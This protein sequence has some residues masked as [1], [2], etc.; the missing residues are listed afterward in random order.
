MEI[1]PADIAGAALNRILLGTV[2]PRPIAW[3]S[4]INEREQP[5]LAPFSFFN[6][7]CTR[8]PTLLFCPGVRGLD[9]AAKDTLDNIRATGEYVI[10]VVTQTTAEAMNKTATELPPEINEFEFA[11]LTQAPSVKVRPPRVG[12]S[13]VNFECE[14]RQIV[15]IGDGQPGSGWIVIGEIVHLHVAD[16]V[17]LPDHKIDIRALQPVGRLSGY[18]YARINEIFEMERLPPQIPTRKL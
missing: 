18:S 3:V 5:N 13:P 8:P 10:N 9:G 15:D 17:L 6:A 1:N 7:V 11:G 14:L 2:V 16:E 4:T 12:E